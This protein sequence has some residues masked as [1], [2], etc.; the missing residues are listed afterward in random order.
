LATASSVKFGDKRGVINSATETE[1]N[2][3]T[4]PNPRGLVDVTVTTSLGTVRSI[5]AYTFI[6]PP[7]PP[8][9]GEVSPNQG[10]L[11]GEEAVLIR[12]QNLELTTSVTFG[13]EAARITAQEETRLYVTTPA[14]DAGTVDIVITTMTGS[15]TGQDAFTY[16]ARPKFESIVPNEGSIAG[17]DTV[18]I[19]GTDLANTTSVTFDGIKATI[20]SANETEIQ[21]T[22]PPHKEGPVVV[23]V[24]TPGG[25]WALGNAFTYFKEAA[26]ITCYV[27]DVN[28]QNPIL[29]ATIHL[30]RIEPLLEWPI[31][32]STDGYYVFRSVRP[33]TYIMT[34]SAPNYETEISEDITLIA[35]EQATLE[36]HLH[37]ASPEPGDWWCENCGICLKRI[38]AQIA[39]SSMP[40]CL[41]EAPLGIVSPT[42]TLAIRVTA[43]ASIDPE[44]IWAELEGPDWT[45]T[46]GVWR[47]TLS[48]DDRDG[49]ILLALDEPMPQGD[50]VT[51]TVGAELTDGTTLD[52]IS[53]DFQI[54][55]WNGDTTA[56]VTLTEEA[57]VN[58]LPEIL[59]TP[60]SPVYRIAPA[61]AFLEPVTI[62]IP[63]PDGVN[64]DSLNIY[65]FS[66]SD[67]HNDWYPADNVIGWIVP[68]S[69]QNVYMD[70][71]AYV[72]IQ[73]NHAG[74]L[75]LVKNT[76]LPFGNASVVELG[77]G[78]GSSLRWVSLVAAILALC[79]IL[80]KLAAR[81]HARESDSE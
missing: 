64:P 1:L 4:P 35:N 48:G 54:G 71:R 55:P 40:L 6:D 59:G 24:T 52:P 19:T 53:K 20:V 15:V 45:A 43:K 27:D 21:V 25:V 41:E 30:G 78:G 2:V 10:I 46:G 18:T 34:V 65:Y 79:I 68:E 33:A 14:H 66:E 26:T 31:A 69:R 3:M 22:T 47:P 72:E 42:D 11:T 49:W 80:G 56:P 50:A 38:D 36:F 39:E 44:S 76:S 13:G 17:G 57:N 37:P 61:A 23:I 28:T 73:V 16:I 29:D 60:Q 5:G 51:M 12:G 32:G 58:T 74:I 81:N 63:V 9:F 7:G 75:Q 8:E 77:T 62:Q 70:N 67:L